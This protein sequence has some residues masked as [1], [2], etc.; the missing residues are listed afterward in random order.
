V[1]YFKTISIQNTLVS[2]DSSQPFGCTLIQNYPNPFN[3]TTTIQYHLTQPAHVILKIYNQKGQFIET[4]VNEFN[5]VGM[6]HVTWKASGFPSGLY[7]YKIQAGEFSDL[8][9]LILQK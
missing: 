2:E 4:L 5:P 9:K 6:H 8:Q 3:L 1:K 7:F